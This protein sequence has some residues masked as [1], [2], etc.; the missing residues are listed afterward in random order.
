MPKWMQCI[1]WTLVFWLIG[2][3]TSYKQIPIKSKRGAVFWSLFGGFVL[4]M[5]PILMNLP[6]TLLSYVFSLMFGYAMIRIF[7]EAE[8]R[9]KSNED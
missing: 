3:A 6:N 8:K 7:E 4:I 1:I 2:F 9:F 5:V